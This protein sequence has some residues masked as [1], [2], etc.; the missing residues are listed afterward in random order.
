LA[1]LSAWILTSS[2][3]TLAIELTWDW[4]I[5]AGMLGIVGGILG[6][7]YPAVRAARQ[8]PVRALRDE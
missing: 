4:T 1:R 3:P 8:D 6:S 7:F 5:Y 2:Y